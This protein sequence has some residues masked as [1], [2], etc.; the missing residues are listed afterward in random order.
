[1]AHK[2]DPT[3]EPN[4]APHQTPEGDDS[5]APVSRKR[6]NIILGIIAL[7]FVLAGIGWYLLDAL[8]L[9]TR[10][11]TD[12]AYVQGDQVNISAQI[13][14]T[15]TAINVEDTEPVT[16]GQVLIELD[17]S[18]TRNA[19][20][21]AAG[22]LAQAVRHYRQQLAQAVQL[23]AATVTARTRLE[24]AR[25]EYQ[26]RKPLLAQRAASREEVDSARRQYD[27]AQAQ[28][29]QARA[30]ARA[31]H[32]LI[33]G[34]DLWHDPGVLQARGAYRN[35]W[36]AQDRTRVVSPVEG[37]VPAVRCSWVRACRPVNRC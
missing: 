14:A 9:S 2:P 32:A 5:E 7:V 3:P 12:D 23:D 26:R 24:R 33:D 16:R 37:R 28:F 35:A 4:A 17:D 18:N 21:Q 20:D 25:D 13:N 8:V 11:I 36:L 1:M 10:V 27:A 29:E 22:Q 19:L 31:A 34:N 30:Q 6:R 15:V